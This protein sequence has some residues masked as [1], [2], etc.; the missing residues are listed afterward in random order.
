MLE[1]WEDVGPL[2]KPFGFEGETPA[3][4]SPRIAPQLVGMG[5]LEAIAEG[6]PGPGRPGRCG[7]RRDFG[8]PFGH[9]Y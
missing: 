4:Y 8:S 1:A 5:L 2:R 6:Y 9:R 7:W 3:H